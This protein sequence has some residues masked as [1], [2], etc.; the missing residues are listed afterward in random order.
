[1]HKRPRACAQR[2]H[3]GIDVARRL[4]RRVDQVGAGRKHFHDLARD[5]AR[6]V[7]VVDRHVAEQS[8]R[9]G[10]IFRRRRR[11]IA[12]D[13]RRAVRARRSLP[14]PAARA[15]RRKRGIEAA[16]EADHHRRGERCQAV[17]AG[18]RAGGVE[19]DRLL[20]QDGPAGP[21]R[22]LRSEGTCVGVGVAISTARTSGIAAPPRP[23]VLREHRVRTR[24]APPPQVR[25]RTRR[26]AAPRDGA[27]VHPHASGRSARIR[28]PP[29]RSSHWPPVRHDLVPTPM[30]AANGSSAKMSGAEM[31]RRIGW[32]P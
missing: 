22:G 9:G 24:C 31:G 5:R 29:S 8:A 14:P 30:M 3:C 20:A 6:H 10:D 15:R 16:V 18:R 28:A 4:D 32:Q 12:A 1:M 7:E 11:R 21:C 25:C 17:A 26:P 19:V 2:Q 23:M 13:D 27:R